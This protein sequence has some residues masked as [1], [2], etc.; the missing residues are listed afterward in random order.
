M[1]KLITLLAA[2]IFSVAAFAQD[3]LVT[4]SSHVENVGDDTYRVV[5]T[6]KVASGYH[7]YTLTDEFS[8]TEIMD[9]A[10]DGGKLVGEPYEI[11]E[12]VEELDE[13]GEMAR[14]YYDKIVIAQ[15]IKTDGES[16]VYTG[17]IFTNACTGGA[18]K[19]EYY[20]FEV[21]VD[22]AGAAMAISEDTAGE[23]Q[24]VDKGTVWSL[25]L[26]A[27]IWGFAMLLTPCVFPMV[28]MTVSFFMKGSSSVAAGRFKAG[29][30]G[31][32]IVLCL[33]CA[34]CA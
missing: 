30:Y 2:V 3:Q 14:H 31:F 5:F 18:C 17:A 11:G 1:K 20:D 15:N 26:Q 19:A 12:P 6:G 25:I 9:A 13:F 32:F 16:A 34:T 8:A 28:P 21:N 7:T 22:P 24:P 10:V 29:M 33:A 4:W 27:I 23:S